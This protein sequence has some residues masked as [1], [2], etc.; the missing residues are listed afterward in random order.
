[1]ILV[2]VRFT[3][4]SGDDDEEKTTAE[5]RLYPDDPSLV[6]PISGRGTNL[7]ETV[8]ERGVETG[9]DA[10]LASDLGKQYGVLMPSGSRVYTVKD[11]A[12]FLIA[13]MAVHKGNAY[14]GRYPITE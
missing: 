3:S 2:G 12:R 4:R 8:L 5:F 7:V 13:L 11:G 1:M 10:A 9:S 14:G 6:V